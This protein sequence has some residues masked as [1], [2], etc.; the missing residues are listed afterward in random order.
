MPAMSKVTY[1][2]RVVKDGDRRAGPVRLKGKELPYPMDE[3]MA[4]QHERNTGRAL[5][6]VPGSEEVVSDA[7]EAAGIR[8]RGMKYQAPGKRW[9]P[10]PRLTAWPTL[11]RERQTWPSGYGE[12]CPI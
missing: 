11:K 5:E 4:R 10:P 12:L 8:A 1:R 3:D 7:P 6:K 2:W 9:S